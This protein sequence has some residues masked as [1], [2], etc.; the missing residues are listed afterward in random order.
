M[1]MSAT[2]L[3]LAWVAWAEK[4]GWVGG[5]GEHVPSGGAV[6]RTSVVQGA[7]GHVLLLPAA[8]LLGTRQRTRRGQLGLLALPAWTTCPACQPDLARPG[9]VIVP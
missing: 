5:W 8:A 2:Q 7:A 4:R 3:M 1:S 9:L 6:R